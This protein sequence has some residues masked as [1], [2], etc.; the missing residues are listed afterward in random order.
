MDFSPADPQKMA[1]TSGRLLATIRPAIWQPGPVCDLA[2]GSH[3]P[4][5]TSASHLVVER[6]VKDDHTYSKEC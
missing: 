4:R 5:I 3:F 2:E 6:M 1:F